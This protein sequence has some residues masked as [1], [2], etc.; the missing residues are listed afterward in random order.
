[1]PRRCRL[2]SCLDW[3]ICTTVLIKI[4]RHIR[5]D[6][7]SARGRSPGG[8]VVARLPLS[9]FVFFRKSLTQPWLNL[10]E[11]QSNDVWQ[12]VDDPDGSFPVVNTHFC[13]GRKWF[14]PRSQ[15]S[16][17]TPVINRLT[18]NLKLVWIIYSLKVIFQDQLVLERFFKFHKTSI[19]EKAEISLF[20][21][22]IQD[23]FRY[24]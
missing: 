21:C 15:D 24:F 6:Q 9:F 14:H 2:R 23:G 3:L 7:A 10:S 5:T 11:A 17:L 22:V 13:T 20:N 8:T 12:V 19:W 16:F 1:M 4:N 18:S